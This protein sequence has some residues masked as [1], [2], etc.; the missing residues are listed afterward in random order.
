[1]TSASLSYPADANAFPS[2]PCGDSH[3]LSIPTP[4]G[5]SPAAHAATRIGRRSLRCGAPRRLLAPLSIGANHAPSGGRGHS[6]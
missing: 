5:A 6:V 2:A 1:V 3:S 4:W